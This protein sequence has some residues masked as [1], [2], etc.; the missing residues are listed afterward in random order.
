DIWGADSGFVGGT[1]VNRG[2]ISIANTTDPALYQTEHHGM[3]SFSTAVP[4]GNYVV[5]L[6]FAETSKVITGAGQRIFNV[7]VNGV[8][9]NGLDVY[10]QAGGKFN[11]MTKSV[12]VKVTSGTLPIAF[13]T[14][15]NNPEIN[16]IEVVATN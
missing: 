5:Y 6:H 4:N 3:S 13:T 14:V 7:S 2:A 8:T 1:K 9:I 15:V 10:A 11:A 12:T 16:A